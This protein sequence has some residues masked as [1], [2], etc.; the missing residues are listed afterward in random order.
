MHRW[1]FFSTNFFQLS[2]ES[3]KFPLCTVAQRYFCPYRKGHAAIIH[4]G[5]D[6]YIALMDHEDWSLGHTAFAVVDQ[7]SIVD[8]IVQ[9]PFTDQEH[10]QYGTHMRMMDNPMHFTL[11]L[12]E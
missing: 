5:K 6:F 1:D 8:K 12:I 2:H 11:Q 4:P 9:Q 7:L 3:A 10:V